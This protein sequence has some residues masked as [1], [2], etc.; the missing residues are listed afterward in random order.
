MPKD[1]KYAHLDFITAKDLVEMP[2]IMHKRMGL[3]RQIALWAQTELD[4]FN[5][6]ATYNVLNGS[7]LKYVKSALGYFLTTEDSIMGILDDCVCFKPLYPSLHIH[8]ALVWKR[9]AIF[10]KA[11]E[12]L[13]NWFESH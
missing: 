3:Q 9:Y 7:P 2:I 6:V 11:S 12:M 8:F 5:I 10:N 4:Q 13:L 1:C